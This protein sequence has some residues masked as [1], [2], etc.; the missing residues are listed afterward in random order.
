MCNTD[1]KPANRLSVY[2]VVIL[3]LCLCSLVIHEF[4]DGSRHIRALDAPRN[5]TEHG[6]IPDHPDSHD[7]E[8]DFVPSEQADTQI[9]A[10]SAVILRVARL[11]S[12]ATFL[13]PLLPPPK[14]A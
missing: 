4:M 8:D 12:S 5:M 3:C 2:P 9:P 1:K 13:S 6:G 10:V 7:H 11:P 14:A